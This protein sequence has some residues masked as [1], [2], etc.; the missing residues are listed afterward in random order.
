MRFFSIFVLLFGLIAHA[1]QVSPG[2]P[3]KKYDLSA[4]EEQTI[5]SHHRQLNRLMTPMATLPAPLRPFSEVEEAGYLFFSADTSFSSL[6]AK[7]TMA[8]HLPS[9]VTL[10]IF[11]EPYQDRDSILEDYKGVID[12]ARVKVVQI[13]GTRRGFWARDGL[14]IPVWSLNKTMELV[15]ARYYHG[16]EPDDLIGRAFQSPVRKHT[17]YFEG[18][19][20]MVND[21]GVCVMVD[22][23][24]AIDIPDGIFTDT[25]GCKNLIRLPF[26]KGIGHVDESVRFLASK[27]VLT[28]SP[29]YAT[30][31]RQAGLD[32]RMLPR[33][34]GQYETYVNAL[35]VNGTVFVPVYN[36]RNQQE[37][38]DAY[39]AAGMK[40]FPV[41]T[42]TLS[43]DGLGSLHC[44]TMTYPKV[45]FAQ[46][47]KMLG[48]IEL[49]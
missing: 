29:T 14:P 21:E 38:L 11:A 9:G 6:E 19:N 8:R 26:E 25:Y 1:D 27:I 37:A 46:L 7:R 48:A 34:R 36:Q 22:N 15:D 35:L 3:L 43:N 5:R 20:F 33:P 28:D 45:P 23:D 44:I 49:K 4:E 24:R 12:F 10:V 31:L 40:V 30:R 42:S 16:F 32:V 41:E 39:R 2:A 13:R 47:L 17:Y 18:G